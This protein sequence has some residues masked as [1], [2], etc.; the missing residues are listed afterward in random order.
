MTFLVF[1]K[2][3]KPIFVKLFFFKFLIII[4]NRDTYKQ[5]STK[6]FINRKKK[7]IVLKNI[8]WAMSKSDNTIIYLIYNTVDFS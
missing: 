6:Y 3:I 4:I 2:K 7:K 8:F 1:K 5:F